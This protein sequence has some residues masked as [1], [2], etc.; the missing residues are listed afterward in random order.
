MVGLLCMDFYTMPKHSLKNSLSN[1][2]SIGVYITCVTGA[3]EILSGPY[4]GQEKLMRS[5]RIIFGP[6]VR[7]FKTT[8]ETFCNKT[9]SKMKSFRTGDHNIQSIS[10]AE[11][12]V[13]GP[14]TFFENTDFGAVGSC[15]KCRA[16]ELAQI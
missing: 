5:L 10:F 16:A 9:V 4:S 15:Y 7:G 3:E 13:Y 11:T 12:N 14:K 2:I 6:L 1:I 8:S